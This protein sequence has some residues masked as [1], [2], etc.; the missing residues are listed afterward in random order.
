MLIF[1]I[2]FLIAF[3]TTLLIV[4]LARDRVR[5]F[6]ET[7]LAGVQNFHRVPVPRIGGVGLIMGLLAVLSYSCFMDFQQSC[8]LMLLL[9]CSMPAFLSGLVEDLTRRVGVLTRLCFTMLAAVAAFYLLNGRLVRLDVI[10]IDSLLTWTPFAIAFTAFAVGGIANSINIID[11]F[12]GLASAVAIIMLLALACVAYQVN[13][14]MIAQSA[15]AMVGA[16]CGFFLL[17]WP[18]GLLF[19]GDGGAYLVGFWIAELSVLLVFRNPEV[20]PWFPLMV[21]AYPLVETLFSIYRR[22]VVK[23][24]SPGMPD[25]AHLHQIIF[26]RLVRWMV[27]TKDVRHSTMRNSMT[28]PYLWVV[29]SLCIIPALTFWQSSFVLQLSFLMFVLFYIFLYQRLVHFKMPGWLVLRYCS[30]THES[31]CGEI[32]TD[33]D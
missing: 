25:A 13:D 22:V 31:A 6:N 4:Y 29:A 11:G 33:R 8:D 16:L 30:P 14:P 21:V 32:V 17:N 23:K 7:E 19:L 1:V 10:G 15:L 9:L 12:N 26:K 5:S 18:W 3:L 2:A 27:G 20:S 28:S 24:V